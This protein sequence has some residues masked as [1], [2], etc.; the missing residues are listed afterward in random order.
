MPIEKLFRVVIQNIARSKKNFVFSSIGIIVG[1]STFTFFLA[2]SQGI[3]DRV[4]NKIFPIDQLEIE[5]VGGVAASAS[6]SSSGEGGITALS[7]GPRRLDQT[8]ITQLEGVPGVAHVYPKMRARFA[9]KI[10]TGVL[11]RRMA[12]EGFMEGLDV[13]QSVISEMS[14]FEAQCELKE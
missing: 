6:E 10:E 7:G 13:S 11:D 14:A 4:L 12:G 5:P 9:A 1:I 8:A 2:L 3:Q